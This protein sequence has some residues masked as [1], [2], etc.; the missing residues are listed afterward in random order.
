MTP[1]IESESNLTWIGGT[2]GSGIMKANAVGRI[3]AARLQGH[4]D[5]VLADG[6][7]F[8]VSMLSMRNWEVEYGI[9]RKMY[10]QQ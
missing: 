7:K 3:A 5:A 6:S 10:R 4:S 2:S 8:R 1:V 9:G